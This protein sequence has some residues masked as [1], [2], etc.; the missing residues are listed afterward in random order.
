MSLY[1]WVICLLQIHIFLLC[2]SAR[3]TCFQK[4]IVSN[5]KI[6]E[7]GP[8]AEDDATSS[9]RS[10]TYTYPQGRGN[11]GGS[12]TKKS[13]SLPDSSLLP[14]CCLHSDD[15]EVAGRD[16][17]SRGHYGY[18]SPHRHVYHRKRVTEPSSMS[19][20]WLLKKRFASKSDGDSP[21]FHDVYQTNSTIT[22]G[23]C[24]N[25]SDNEDQWN[26]NTELWTQ[27]SLKRCYWIFRLWRNE[28][29]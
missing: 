2:K 20:E 9:D 21:S 24:I 27:N 8:R 12:S 3:V 10:R 11:R 18:G 23:M 1:S 5:L 13:H 17:R 15:E 14:L 26:K 16:L 19:A 25:V 4:R 6:D 7:G 29:W 28:I 22:T